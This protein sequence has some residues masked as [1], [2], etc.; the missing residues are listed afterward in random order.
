MW[1]E[2]YL[3]K[4]ISI[5]L[6]FFAFT[7]LGAQQPQRFELNQFQVFSM[8]YGL[9]FGKAIELSEQQNFKYFIFRDFNFTS[10]GGIKMEISDKRKVEGKEIF[11]KFKPNEI[12]MFT[13]AKL[14]FKIVAFNEK[15]DLDPPAVDVNAFLEMMRPVQGKEGSVEEFE[16]NSVQ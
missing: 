8:A 1:K 3:K 9:S 5:F 2:E 7:T 4:F 12:P 10:K 6:L 15:P 14:S 13:N 16:G 11:Y